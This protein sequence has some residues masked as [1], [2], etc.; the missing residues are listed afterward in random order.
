[1]ARKIEKAVHPAQAVADALWYTTTFWKT[2]VGFWGV[3]YRKNSFFYVFGVTINQR[4]N[5][6]ILVKI[7]SKEAMTVGELYTILQQRIAKIK[8]GRHRPKRKKH[9]GRYN[10]CF[11]SKYDCEFFN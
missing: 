1:M 4:H 3:E 2:T 10:N 9:K 6:P 5:C 8:N 7:P 11:L